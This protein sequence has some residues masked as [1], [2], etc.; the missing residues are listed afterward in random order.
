[1]Q[2]LVHVQAYMQNGLYKQFMAWT[3]IFQ[4]FFAIVIFLM[5]YFLIY[6]FKKVL[7]VKHVYLQAS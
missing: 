2:L 7:N 3:K 1:M 6:K 5:T 4:Q